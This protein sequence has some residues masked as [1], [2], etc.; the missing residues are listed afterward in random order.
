MPSPA[1]YGVAQPRPRDPKRTESHGDVSQFKRRH[2]RSI[3]NESGCMHRFLTEAARYRELRAG[4]RMRSGAAMFRVQDCRRVVRS[5]PSR[6]APLGPHAFLSRSRCERSRRAL[7]LTVTATSFSTFSSP[8]FALPAGYSRSGCSPTGPT[9]LHRH[10]RT[11][12]LTGSWFCDRV[13]GSRF[14]EDLYGS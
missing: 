13:T 12:C 4:Q 3:Q 7:H 9:P 11:T 14:E 1:G 10:C 6:A 5:W 2:R 8:S